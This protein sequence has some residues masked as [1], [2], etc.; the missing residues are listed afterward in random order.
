MS[1]SFLDFKKKHNISATRVL[2]IVIDWVKA[3]ETEYQ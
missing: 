1:V 3:R 2:L